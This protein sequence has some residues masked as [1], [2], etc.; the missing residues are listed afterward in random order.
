MAEP[1]YGLNAAQV[2]RVRR[3]LAAI[4]LGR[5][6]IPRMRNNFAQPNQ[7]KLAYPTT[8]VQPGTFKE[9]TFSWYSATD[10]TLEPT[11]N[12][13]T[14]T[15]C[16]DW[17]RWGFDKRGRALAFRPIPSRQY[18]LYQPPAARW[19]K[20]VA[21]TTAANSTSCDVATVNPSTN[22]RGTGAD[23]ATTFT[24]QLP[25][26]SGIAPSL[27]T[28]DV[29]AYMPTL[30]GQL[31]AVSDYGTASA[32]AAVKYGWAYQITFSTT[33]RNSD[34]T[35]QSV[36]YGGGSLLGIGTGS[37]DVGWQNDTDNDWL[38][39]VRAG[40]YKFDFS[41]TGFLQG[42]PT[43]KPLGTGEIHPMLDTFWRHWTLASTG[44]ALF[45][46]NRAVTFETTLASQTMYSNIAG[47]FLLAATTDDSARWYIRTDNLAAT[48]GFG[49]ENISVVVT[50]IA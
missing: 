40:T 14:Q 19:G 12:L 29:I 47:S 25:M 43:T 48:D 35:G 26:R 41:G 13:S 31:V 32:A 16:F 37:S 22:S 8:D 1:F 10:S 21:V 17:F 38:K 9:T 33:L 44:T 15:T 18:Y 28:G 27:T 49:I 2:D 3:A 34:S 23:T 7:L 50:Q 42:T 11:D 46:S 5:P 39:C 36:G 6:D 20:V 24:V 45:G 30:F 4:E